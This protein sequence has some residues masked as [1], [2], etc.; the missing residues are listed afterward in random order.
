MV[1]AVLLTG[2]MERTIHRVDKSDRTELDM[3]RWP[4]V[5]SIGNLAIPLCRDIPD[6]YVTSPSAFLCEWSQTTECA[7]HRLWG[8]LRHSSSS[9]SSSSSSD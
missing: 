4:H 6:K 1:R 7:P 8:P 2:Q 9:S 5:H 3:H